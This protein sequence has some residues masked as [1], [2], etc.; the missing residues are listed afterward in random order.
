MDRIVDVTG[1]KGGNAFL[2]LGERKTALIDCGMAY[3][4]G[5]LINNIRQVLAARSLDF[6]LISHSHYDH[7]G[8]IPYLKGTWPDTRVLGAEY[9]MRI[10]NRQNALQTIKDLGRQAALLYGA[11][12]PAEY[13][14]A[15]LKVD[16][17]LYDGDMLE[18]GGLRITVLATKGHTQCSLSFMLSNGTLFPSETTGYMSKAGVVYPGFITSY[19]DAIDSIYKCRAANPRFIISPHLGLL[20]AAE[21]AGYWDKCLTAIGDTRKFILGLFAQGY[22]N[23][24]IL[25]AYEKNFRDEESRLEQP[26]SAFAL[27]AQGMI[28][29]VLKTKRLLT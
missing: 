21:A 3:C 27:N 20:S 1:G 5:Q 28:K 2:I 11:A 29:T 13:D 15:L 14:N 4:A 8:A 17:C 12:M 16:Q 23:E 19:T 25:T 22:T 7:I 10:L 26:F 9:A 18:L 24:E 6:I